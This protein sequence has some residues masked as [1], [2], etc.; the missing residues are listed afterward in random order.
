MSLIDLYKTQLRV[1]WE[2]RGGPWA[3][4]KRLVHHPARVDGLVPGDGWLLPR[5]TVDSFWAAAFAVVLMALFNAIVRT[6]LLAFVAARSLILTGILVIVLQVVAF[7][8]VAQWAP[9][10][11]VDGFLTALIGSFVFA[12]INTVLTSILGVD[13]G[14]SY[15]GLL[16]QTLLVERRGRRPTSPGLVIIQI[17]GLAHPILAGR[18]RAGSVNTMAGLVRDGSHNLSRWEAILPSMTSASQAGIL[19]GTND[20]IPAFRWY[21][22]DREHLMVSSNPNDAARDRPPPVQRRRPPLEQRRQHLQPDDGRRHA[23][24]PHDRRDQGRGAG[25][26]RQPGL[27][28]LLLQPDRLSALVH[29]VPW[30]VHQGDVPGT[31]DP[32]GG[33]PPQMH[34]GL[35]YAG[36]RAASNV[37]LRDVNTSLIIEEMYRGANVIYADF[38]DYDELAHHCGPERVESLEA[39]DGVDARDRQPGQ[40]GR[41]RAPAVQVHRPVRP[42]PEPRR[43]VQ[44]ALRPEP[45]RGRPRPDGRPGD[46]RPV[47]R[48]RPRVRPS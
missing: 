28:R 8:I 46:R 26:R 30:R 12:F 37:L 24:V 29:D 15:Y 23:R 22:R 44:A 47:R 31:P 16:I 43:D 11:H 4:F 32:P 27:P 38:T 25:H 10:V 45:R 20:G 18:M 9:G 19:H 13:R 2:W 33:D 7:L 41:G 48:P 3:L 42:R 6:V 5:I 1:L 40:G 39:L 17:D 36:M 14:G 34:R 21:E 35:K